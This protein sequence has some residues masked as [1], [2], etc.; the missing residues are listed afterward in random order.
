MSFYLAV[1]RGLDP[2]PV[3]VIERLKGELARG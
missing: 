1:L 2:S 3:P